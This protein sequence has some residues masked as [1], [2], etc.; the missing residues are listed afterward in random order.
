MLDIE[1]LSVNISIAFLRA[2]ITES[3]E[4][5]PAIDVILPSRFIA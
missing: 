4:S 5:G 3:P 1:L 2:S